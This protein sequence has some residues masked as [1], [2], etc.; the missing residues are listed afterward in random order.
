VVSDPA[1][2]SE[3][4]QVDVPVPE[5]AEATIVV[6]STPQLTETPKPTET[7]SPVPI[8]DQ[9]I[10]MEKIK[11][12]PDAGDWVGMILIVSPIS[13]GAFS[14]AKRKLSIRWRIRIAILALIGGFSAYILTTIMV[15]V[16]FSWI[17]N[18]RSIHI[19]AFSLIGALAGVFSGWFW[20]KNNHRNVKKQ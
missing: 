3:I 17:E 10:I 12:V 4:R 15:L 8:E 1:Y 5:G 20:Y 2:N 7:I 11:Q 16:K 19:L 18:I 6:L 14:M 13:F 9:V